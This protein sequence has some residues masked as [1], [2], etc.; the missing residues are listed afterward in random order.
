MHRTPLSRR[1][2]D[3]V[4]ILGKPTRDC[5][6]VVDDHLVDFGPYAERA[7]LQDLLE[8]ALLDDV[9][10]AAAFDVVAAAAAPADGLTS[11]ERACRNGCIVDE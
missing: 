1:R 10:A 9:L 11:P 6:H 7:L 8:R 3:V 2:V 5:D 4:E